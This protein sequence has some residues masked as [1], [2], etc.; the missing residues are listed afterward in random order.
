[1]YGEGSNVRGHVSWRLEKQSRHHRERTER[2]RD[3]TVGE[4]EREIDGAAD[5]EV[6][7]E[8]PIAVV[9]KGT[10]CYQCRLVERNWKTIEPAADRCSLPA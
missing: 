4:P 2:E 10:H 5:V 8:A 1:V 7:T 6:A 3:A 9:F